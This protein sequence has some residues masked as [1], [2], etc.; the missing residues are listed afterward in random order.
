MTNKI[1]AHVYVNGQHTL[2]ATQTAVLDAHFDSWETVSV[3]NPDWSH[4]ETAEIV[5]NLPDGHNIV[6]V[7]P[8]PVQ[9]FLGMVMGDYPNGEVHVSVLHTDTH[10]E[11]E[12][13]DT[14]TRPAFDGWRI[15]HLK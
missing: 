13:G 1:H 2:L 8:T 4:F 9:L 3:W 15:T 12:Y 7:L 11:T 14:I 5:A 10:P 6:V